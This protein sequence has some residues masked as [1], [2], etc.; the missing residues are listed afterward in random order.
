MP[1]PADL[2][3]EVTLFNSRRAMLDTDKQPLNIPNGTTATIV[4]IIAGG[5][6]KVKLTGTETVITVFSGSWGFSQPDEDMLP[7]L[8]SEQLR[9]R[10]RK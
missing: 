9:K 1:G 8:R 6:L 2:G 3:R 5:E 7:Y 10:R 4:E